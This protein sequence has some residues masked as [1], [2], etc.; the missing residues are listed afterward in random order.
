M[1]HS[2][3][4]VLTREPGMLTLET[5]LSKNTKILWRLIEGEAVLID[6]EEGELI[7][8]N[9]VG[10]EIW[11]LIDGQ[12]TLG[13]LTEHLMA[14]F[15]VSERRARKDVQR[16]VRRLLRQDLVEESR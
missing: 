9:E 12:R 7:R 4:K 13:D 15:E 8:L 6:S 2:P 5:R 14:G 11:K 1:E 3:G 10:A 16:F